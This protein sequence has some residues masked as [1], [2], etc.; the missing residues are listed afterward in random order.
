MGADNEKEQSTK[1]LMDVDKSNLV[2]WTTKKTP[3]VTTTILQFLSLT[4]CLY[5]ERKS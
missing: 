2:K 5:Q 1:V 4:I 3:Q